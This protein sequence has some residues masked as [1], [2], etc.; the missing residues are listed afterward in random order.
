MNEQKD[1]ISNLRL[2]W[3]NMRNAGPDERRACIEA[4][5]RAMM[6]VSKPYVNNALR[7]L[8]LGKG[9]EYFK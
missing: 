9:E 2:A 7:E 4:M 6:D 5:D 8:G 1:V 3:F